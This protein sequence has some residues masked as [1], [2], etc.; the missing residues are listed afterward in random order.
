MRCGQCSIFQVIPQLLPVKDGAYFNCDHCSSK[1]GEPSR[2]PCVVHRM[3]DGVV[4]RSYDVDEMRKQAKKLNAVGTS[5]RQ[6][7]RMSTQKSR[8][9]H[10][11]EEQRLRRIQ[12]SAPRH[13][14]RHRAPRLTV[15]ARATDKGE[16]AVGRYHREDDRR[17][18]TGEHRQCALCVASPLTLHMDMGMGMHVCA[19]GC[20]T[21]S[22]LL[23]LKPGDIGTP[24]QW[25]ISDK[26]R[27]LRPTTDVPE[28]ERPGTRGGDTGHTSDRR[29][30]RVVDRGRE[31]WPR[32]MCDRRTIKRI[33]LSI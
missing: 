21:Q 23:D 15:R 31:R 27:R 25:A 29:F 2:Q 30:C 9:L 8:I 16:A 1:N 20:R 22:L 10:T 17:P 14:S 18:R 12:A 13:R 5:D 7:A 33:E 3:P 32:T 19:R 11:L 28:R 4:L 6:D 24:E 26:C